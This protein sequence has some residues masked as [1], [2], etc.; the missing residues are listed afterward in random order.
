MQFFT[1][2]KNY[3]GFASTVFASEHSAVSSSS[4]SN[5]QHSEQQQQK[6]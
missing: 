2:P 4:R 5:E 3:K 6:Q 1:K